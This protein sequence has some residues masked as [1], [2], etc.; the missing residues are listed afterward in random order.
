MSFGKGFEGINNRMTETKSQIEFDPNNRFE[1]FK[2]KTIEIIKNVFDPDMRIDKCVEKVVE[3]ITTRNEHL[4]GQRH[5]LTL[6]LFQRKQIELEN[7]KK[8][9]GIFPEFDYKFQAV[10]SK[11]LYLESDFIQFKEC[12][13]QLLNE[14]QNNLELKKEFN[15]DQIQQI[16]DGIY[17]GSSPDG[18]VWHHSPELGK[19][20]LVD[21]YVHA[22]TGHTGGRF[23]WGGGNENR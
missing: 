21:S 7:N 13:K 23:V 1:Q 14:I 18:Y 5:P 9:E 15:S 3:H 11:E 16:K 10:I 4:E 22:V 20:E 17:D 8:I 2:E 19:I 12:N 6:V